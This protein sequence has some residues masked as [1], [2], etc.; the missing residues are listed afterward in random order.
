MDTWA[1]I[2]AIPSLR[3][4]L[5]R[6]HLN[7]GRTVCVGKNVAKGSEESHFT[8]MR[9]GESDGGMDVVGT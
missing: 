7:V 3:S 6:P 8:G 5:S 9:D 2:A 1:A 4:V